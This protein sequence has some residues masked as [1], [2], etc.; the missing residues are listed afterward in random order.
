MTRRPAMPVPE[1]IAAEMTRIVRTASELADLAI[2]V[3]E[4]YEDLYD[5]AYRKTG[6]AGFETPIGRGNFADT[7]PTGS[8]AASG[9]HKRMRYKVGMAAKPLRKIQPKLLQSLREMKEAWDETT[10]D[11]QERLRLI[12]ELEEEIEATG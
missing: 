12:R 1:A 5:A 7:D 6:G 9:M 2:E 4:S 11:G 10:P 3:S 8:V